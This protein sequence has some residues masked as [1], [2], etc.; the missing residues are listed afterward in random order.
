M[1]V[2]D[3]RLQPD[4]MLSWFERMLHTLRECEEIGAGNHRLIGGTPAPVLA[5]VAEGATGVVL[6]VHNLCEQPQH[7]RLDD[8][9]MGE[10]PPV[11]VFADHAYEG[12]L[13][14]TDLELDPFGFRWIRLQRSHGPAP[15]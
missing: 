2:T 1:N 8:I 15:G 11:E 3:Q 6:F 12:E 9:P 5:H 13:D 4:S 10:Q 7:V 14:P